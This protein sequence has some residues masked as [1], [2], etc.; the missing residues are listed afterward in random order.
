MYQV[1]LVNL[2]E[3]TLTMPDACLPYDITSMPTLVSNKESPRLPMR[4]SYMVSVMD[5]AP[6]RC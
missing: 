2:N 1:A 5:S 3:V 4:M 6:L